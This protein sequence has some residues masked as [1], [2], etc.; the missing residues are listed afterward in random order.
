MLEKIRDGSQ[1]MI[2][3]VI[4]GFVI[5]TFALAGV[6]SYLGNTSEVPVATVNGDEITKVQFD[7]AY[8][9]ERA[10]MQ[11]QFGEMFGMLSADTNYMSNFRNSVLEKLIDEQLQRQLV[12]QL[13]LMVS[14]DVLRDTIRTMPEFQVDGVFN[15]DRY[16]ALLRQNGYEPN[17]FRDY[18]RAQMSA[19]QLVVG[20]AGSEF[21]TISEMQ[22][23][24]KLQQQSRDIQYA[25]LK[26]ADFA[27]AVE[28]NDQLLQDYYQ[29][30]TNQFVS[31]ETVSVDYVQLTAADIAKSVVVADADL[32]AYYDANQARYQTEERRRVSH[33]LLESAEDNAEIKAK[34]DAL[35]LQLQQG[36]DFAELA[37]KESADTF[38]A[39]KGGDLDFIE[40]GVMDAEFEKAAYALAKAGDISP[41]VKTEFGYHIIKLTEVQPGSTK[42]FA[43]VKEQILATVKEEKAAEKFAELQQLLGEKS[44]E[45][46]DSLQEAAEAVGTKVVS[47]PAFSRSAAPAELTAPKVLET[48][49]SEDFIS[50]GVNS[51]VIE[52]APQHVVVV[53]VNAHQ[54]ETTKKLE[55]VKAQVQAAVVA[56]KSSE[57]AKAKAEALLAE[58]VAGK[59]LADVVAA[60]NLTLETKAAVTRFG[61]DVDSD[62]RTK[63]FEL[64]KPTEA[65]PA[66][67]AMLNLASGDAAL[68]AVTK[69][70]DTEVTTKPPVEQLQ[71]FADQKAQSS[72]GALLA[73]LKANAEIT[74]SLPA[75]TVDE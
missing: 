48:L 62:I 32:Q 40:K 26:A 68:V 44:F 10:R 66:T 42:A 59:S 5:L 6:G 55:E 22:L 35:A 75:A 33:I 19:N 54:P 56:T 61:G 18:L 64:A 8:Q 27:S 2:A 70:T 13:D 34:A 41:V 69:V 43:D 50:A 28:I 49:F 31:P 36:A 9:N 30:N 58:V 23:L 45:I 67:V 1:G 51:D 37:K 7:T 73:A 15:N 74:R 72:F 21:A 52:V 24:S 29:S 38:S 20:L 65:Q 60:A 53:R 71:Q 25:V 16:I 17:Q 63:A 46:A 12:S 3:K 11:Q 47:V 4:L 14:D 39:E 57:L